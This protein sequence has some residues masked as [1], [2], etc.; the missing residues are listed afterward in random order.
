MGQSPLIVK[1]D[2]DAAEMRIRGRI[3]WTG[4]WIIVLTTVQFV[5][6]F[7]TLTRQ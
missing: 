4:I 3:A 7:Y 5:C 2:L 1:S 6:L